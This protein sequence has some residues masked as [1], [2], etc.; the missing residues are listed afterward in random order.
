MYITVEPGCK[1]NCNRRN[2]TGRL[3]CL[4]QAR[5]AFHLPVTLPTF[6]CALGQESIPHGARYIRKDRL[7][8]MHLKLCHPSMLSKI[9]VF[10]QLR[11]AHALLRNP[12]RACSF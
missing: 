11:D 2:A 8:H 6:G 3:V 5:A 10:F 12:M 7:G 1:M 4:F 9:C